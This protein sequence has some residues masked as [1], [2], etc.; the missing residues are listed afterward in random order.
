MTGDQ[1]TEIVLLATGVVWL[2]WE[3]VTVAKRNAGLRWKTI[4]M[5]LQHR[6]W[7]FAI[8]PYGW[9]LLAGHW[10]FARAMVRPILGEPWIYVALLV[11]TLAVIAWDF[12]WAYLSDE[13]QMRFS[14]WRMPGFW[15]LLGVIVGAALWPQRAT[16]G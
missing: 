2:A 6:G 1:I 12:G 11:V 5:V 3:I 13:K 10:W 4:S 16:W 7:R 9:G 8:I 15:V 14:T